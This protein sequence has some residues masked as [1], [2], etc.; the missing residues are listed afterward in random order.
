M[1]TAAHVVIDAAGG[2]VGGAARWTA[3]LDGFLAAQP[4]PVP[5]TVIGR[6]L[7]LTPGWLLRRE[8]AARSAHIAIAS[9][10]VSFAFASPHRRV[11]VRNALHFLH[12]AEDH[13]LARMPRGFRAQIP[14]VR[15]LLR[16]AEV[17]VA[18]TSAMA[19]R[20]CHH[21]PAARARVVVRP[22]PVT[23]AGER[24]VA[25]EPF[26]LVPVL[27]AP[28]KNLLPELEALLSA[29]DRTGRPI[30]VRLTA[31]P[32]DLPPALV[33]HPR[34]TLLGTLPHEALNRLWR[35]AT[36]IFFPSCVEAFGYPLAEARAYGIPVLAPDTDQNR[37]VAA[38]ALRPYRSGSRESLAEALDGLDEPVCPDPRAFD[39]DA[40]FR[41]L[42]EPPAGLQ[43]WHA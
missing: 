37:E 11:L 21:I 26:I 24:D 33:R 39:R 19:E 23:P 40:Y 38:N 28:Y 4:V 25:D 15:Q 22:H 20:V 10:N 8:H 35:T 7:G 16:R 17:I 43:E 30:V 34:L 5:V 41:W 2:V 18:P 3:E 32:E 29:I 42:F 13:L 27:P 1:R 14:V 31:R 9:N 12:P 6:R 36:A